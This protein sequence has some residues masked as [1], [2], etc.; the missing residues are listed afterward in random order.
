MN[1]V[2]GLDISTTTVGYCIMDSNFNL[3]ELSY[4]KLDKIDGL[5]NKAIALQ[6]V[7][8]SYTDIVTDV[9]IEEPLVRFKEGY[10]SAQVLSML[11]QFNGMCNILTHFVYNVTPVLYNVSNARKLAFPNMKFPTG[12]HRKEVVRTRVAQEYT[13]IDWPFKH[14]AKNPDGTPKLKDECW[15]MADALVISRCHVVSL[16]KGK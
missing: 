15:D 12:C 13:N 5:I 4:I 9:S 6:T 14:K 2:L 3:H 16:N 7:L 11:S 1:Y 10:S 8:Q